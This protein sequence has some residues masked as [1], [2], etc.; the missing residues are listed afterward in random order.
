MR[1]KEGRHKRGE[2]ILDTASAHLSRLGYKRM[3]ADDVTQAAQAG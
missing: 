2:R 3:T 1:T